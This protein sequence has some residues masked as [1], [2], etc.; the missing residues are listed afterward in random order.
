MNK[1]LIAHVW[2][3]G[4]LL[5]PA[6]A[7]GQQHP[8][9]QRGFSPENLY[10]FDGAEQVDIRSG[11]LTLQVPISGGFPLNGGNFYGFTASLSTKLWS[12]EVINTQVASHPND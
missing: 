6:L 9:I 7:S 12:Y 5:L 10:Q 4:A 11:N 3:I 1:Q 8:S 2:I